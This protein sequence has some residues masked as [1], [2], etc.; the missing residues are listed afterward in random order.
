MKTDFHEALVGH[1]AVEGPSNRSFGL[2]VG[3]IFMALGSGRSLI[4]WD[5]DF[6]SV[7]MLTV[8]VALLSLAA[9]SPKSL[10][11]A[12]RL[13]MRLG[14]LL[15][16]IINPLV[17]LLVYALAFVP[18]GFV[19]RLRGHDPLRLKHAAAGESYWIRRPSQDSMV[20][21][22]SKQF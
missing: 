5:L 16:R 15:A 7:M 11:S 14:A 10:G 18:I 6:T 9:V 4:G 8:G 1:G 22:M 2:T 3:G 17:L 12:N 20:E 19:M 13:W 21:R